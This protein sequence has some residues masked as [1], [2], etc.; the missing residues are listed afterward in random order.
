ME[1]ER[2]EIMPILIGVLIQIA[3]TL[4]SISVF[5]V[6]INLANVDYKY[7]PVLGSVAMAL[8]A[9]AGAFYLSHK[10]GS[11]GY[12]IGSALGGITFVI[13]TLIGLIINDGGL[14]I[15]TLFHLIIIML[16]AIT[17]GVIGVNKK[18]K[19]YI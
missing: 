8:G 15:N 17:G 19:R 13:V 4:L 1:K 5:A 18:G 14:T 16:A 11:K 6:L 2:K 10:K 9:F 3:V 7:S 12:L